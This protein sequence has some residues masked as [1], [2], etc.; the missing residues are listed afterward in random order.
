MIS[1]DINSILICIR[2][3]VNN[4]APKTFPQQKNRPQAVFFMYEITSG[5]FS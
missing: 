1:R 3:V 5:F 2:S 4:T